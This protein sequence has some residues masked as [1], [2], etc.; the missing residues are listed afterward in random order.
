MSA[1]PTRS[2]LGGVN[3]WSPEPE[4]VAIMLGDALGLRLQGR[5]A[6]DGPHFSGR[7]GDM[8]LSVH[9]GEGSHTELAF[10]VEALDS[11]IAEC[12][13]RGGRLIEGPARLP[14]G[15][16]A[17]LSGPADFRMELVEMPSDETSPSRS[18]HDQNPARVSVAKG[19]ADGVP[20]SRDT[21]RGR[22]A[23][24]PPS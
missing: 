19:P 23:P 16:S 11:A 9:P 10:I 18:G 3:I 2:R 22:T 14:Y 12:A 6:D 13:A 8:M 17:H 7:P 1:E 4:R 20:A 24:A 15:I 21:P 5:T